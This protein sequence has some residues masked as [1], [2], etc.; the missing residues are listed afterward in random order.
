MQRTYCCAYTETLSI[1][2]VLLTVKCVHKYIGNIRFH[3]NNGYIN[4]PMTLHYTYVA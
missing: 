4:A 2:I 3:D 1:L